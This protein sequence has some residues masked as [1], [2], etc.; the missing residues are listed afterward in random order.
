MDDPRVVTIGLVQVN[1]GLTWSSP[2][3]GKDGEELSF[4]LLPYSTGLLQSYA[5]RH[6]KHADRLRFV[7][8]IYKRVAVAEGVTQLEDVDVAG[9]S[10]YVWNANLSLTIARELKQR[11]PETLVVVGGPQVPDRA[12]A[13]LR[14]HPYVDIACHGEGEALFTRLLDRVAEG[15]TKDDLAGLS[16]T[17]VLADGD[18]FVHAA[19]A[20]RIADLAQIPSP[21]LEG[22]FD[23]LM[24]SRPSERWVMIWETNR[25]C[26]FSCSFCDW[27]SATA[28]KVYRFEIDRIHEEIRWMGK[29]QIGF[30]FCCDANFGMLPRDVE[31]AKAIVDQKRTSGF[32]F[33]L[34][35]QNTK[36]ATE[37]AYRVQT[38][39]ARELNTLGVTISLQ[40]TSPST[41]DAI[42]RQ[43]IST[44]SFE[45]LQRR[46]AR[47]G[48]YTYTDLIIGLP[49]ESYEAFAGGIS[50]VIES[51]QH[52][53][54][55]F[56][57][58]SV[59]P[60]AEMGHPDYLARYGMQVQ[61]QEIRNVHDRADALEE[62]P[63]HLDLVVGTD[64]MPPADWVRAKVLAWASDALYFDRL[65]QVPLA[66]AA[67]AHGRRVHELVEGLLAAGE[68]DFP[69]LAWIRQTLE[70][71]AREIQQGG[72]SY[73]SGPDSGGILW[74][75]DQWVLLRLVI[76]GRLDAFYR[77]AQGRLAEVLGR[78]AMEGWGNV[79]ADAIELNKALLRVP[80]TTRDAWLALDGNLWEHYQSLLAGDPVE[81]GQGLRFYRIDRTSRRWESHE[82]WF[83]HLVWCY[84]KDKRGY[85]HAVATSR[86]A[87]R[88]TA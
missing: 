58:C 38:L 80:F 28:S 83:E 29:R 71:K 85:L 56:H 37:R 40:S 3:K 10:L 59:L 23:E 54:I 61:P 69:V 63:E 5:R 14:A 44:E 76:D 57:D 33:S 2:G 31:I 84:G 42:R 9:F 8:P 75:A 17:S 4:G 62:V 41:L 66:V 32:P 36:N 88:N 64:A 22:A 30:V 77:E 21:Y 81:L 12:E 67:H 53:H 72:N 79:I 52:N 87:V 47:D 46:F 74:P 49:G 48:V 50:H 73:F 16:G 78:E 70:H 45:E 7:P 43:N 25:G 86:G 65:L 24:A 13:F 60:N 35:V 6:A 27:G 55:Q 15:A 82:A 51:G 19:P 18:R 34:S 68:A 20:A 11:R 1:M 39:I 26:P